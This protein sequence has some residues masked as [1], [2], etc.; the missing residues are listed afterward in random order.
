[1]A[2]VIMSFADLQKAVLYGVWYILCT[3]CEELTPAEP[4][5]RVVYCFHCDK[6]IEIDNPSDPLA[7]LEQC[8]VLGS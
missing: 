8:R 5:A 6:R 7:S 1:M 4:D 2:D 3:H